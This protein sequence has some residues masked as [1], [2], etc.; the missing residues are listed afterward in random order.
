MPIYLSYRWYRRNLARQGEHCRVQAIQ[1]LLVINGMMPYIAGQNYL[2]DPADHVIRVVSTRAEA[3]RVLRP[4]PLDS[5]PKD[6][7][8]PNA[9]VIISTH[10]IPL[11][12]GIRPDTCFCFR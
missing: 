5:L 7:I 4:V 12:V 2:P 3:D 6:N 1:V 11:K 10:Q 9:N 8:L